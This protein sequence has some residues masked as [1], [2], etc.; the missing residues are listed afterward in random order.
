M[1]I[2]NIDSLNLGL[3][4][5]DT[6]SKKKYVPAMYQI[7]FT[8]GWY[9][10]PISVQRKKLLGIK[11]DTNNFPKEERIITKTRALMIDILEQND[12]SNAYINAD[13]AYR[14]ASYYGDARFHDNDESKVDII[15]ANSYLDISE[16][17]ANYAN[18]TNMLDRI[19]KTREKMLKK[20]EQ[21]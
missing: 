19:Q 17:W 14:L 16:K 18:D 11:V 9:S 8:N 21:E 15:N 4:Y 3:K 20:L 7:V 6:L 2:N 13:V 10:D 12:T 1:N 5:M